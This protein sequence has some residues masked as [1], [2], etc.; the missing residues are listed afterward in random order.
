MTGVLAPTALSSPNGLDYV[1]VK[2]KHVPSDDVNIGTLNIK[3]KKIRE[4]L[5]MYDNIDHVP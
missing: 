4:K 3:T 1:K 2:E 5:L